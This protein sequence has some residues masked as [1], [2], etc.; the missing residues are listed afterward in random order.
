[1]S[2]VGIVLVSTLIPTFALVLVWFVLAR[3]LSMR[4]FE[5]C[6]RLCTCTLCKDRGG[7]KHVGIA[8]MG[9]ID[10]SDM[11]VLPFS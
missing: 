5:L 7:N 4:P 8:G 3:L 11:K 10:T 6:H 9:R 2:T 1:M